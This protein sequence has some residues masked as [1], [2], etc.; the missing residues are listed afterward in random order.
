VYKWQ[1][2]LGG[3]AS[4]TILLAGAAAPA[5]AQ[6]VAGS[7]LTE[8]IQSATGSQVTAE[9]CNLGG[10]PMAAQVDSAVSGVTGQSCTAS[11]DPSQS[12]TDSSASSDPMTSALPGLNAVTG[13]IPGLSSMSST[14]SDLTPAASQG[15]SATPDQT[16]P[17]AA[18]RSAANTPSFGSSQ[19]SQGT[20][21]SSPSS[22]QSDAGNSVIPGAVTG[23]TGTLPVSSLTGGLPNLGTVTGTLSQATGPQS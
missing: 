22:N 7:P 20:D 4:A 19:S 13:E 21:Q 9:A 12:S 15:S 1:V 17:L 23:L 6:T 2:F 3:I 10:I 18:P 14:L 8:A 11:T 5:L 16:T